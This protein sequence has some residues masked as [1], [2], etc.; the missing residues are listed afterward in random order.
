[1]VGLPKTLNTKKDWLNAVEYA[2]ATGDGKGVMRS[3]L[4]ELKNN[5]TML[6]L[7]PSAASKPSEEQ[8]PEDFKSVANPGCEKLRLGFTDAEIDQAIGELQ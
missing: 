8:T 7:K 6:V 3:R 4:L 1:M 5:T 2:K